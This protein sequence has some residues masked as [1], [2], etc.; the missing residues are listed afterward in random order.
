MDPRSPQDETTATPGASEQAAKPLLQACPEQ[1]AIAIVGMSGRYPGADSL[2][3]YWRNLVDGRD[4][5]GEIPAT[6]WDVDAYFDPAIPSPGKAYSKWLGSLEDIE[7][8]DPLFFNIAP[9]EAQRMDP[10]Q[11]LFLEEG[12]RAFEDAGLAPQELSESRC[13]VYLGIS[14]S[15]Y[16]TL[17]QQRL[18]LVDMIGSSPAIAA[19][20]IAYFLNLKG[21]AI[22]VDTACSS[23]LVAMHL[24]CQA[25]RNG[26][27]DLALAGGVAL[28]L[29]PEL[30]VC[31]CAAGV[32]SPRGK[33]RTL[34]NQADG[35]VPGEGVGA[36]V[37][38]RLADA[39][40]DGDLIHGLIIGSGINQDGRSNGL[41]APN[42]D[43]QAALLREVYQRHGIDPASIGYVEMHGTG[44]KLGDPI[45]LNALST[46]FREGTREPGFCGL[47]SVKS[48]IGHTSAAAG[49]AGVHKVLLQMRHRQLVPTLNYSSPNEHFDLKLEQS[50]FFVC[51]SAQPWAPTS[52][53]PLRAAVSSFGISGTNA[54]LVLEEYRR[55]QA[56]RSRVELD[57]QHPLLIVLSA[58]RPAQLKSYAAR[59]KGFL[60]N[61]TDV[62]WPALAHT[63]QV[64]RAPLEQ[65]LAFVATAPG[66]VIAT[67]AAFIEGQPLERVVVGDVR[68]SL[69]R[70][71]NFDPAK[72]LTGADGLALLE[73][74]REWVEGTQI[75][76]RSLYPEQPGGRIALP[77]YPFA[78]ERYW[79]EQPPDERDEPGPLPS[80]LQSPLQPLFQYSGSQAGEQRFSTTLTGDEFFLRDHQVAGQ[81]LV[82]AAMQLE[83]ARAAMAQAH[84]LPA[85][86]PVLLEEITWLRPLALRSPL[87]VH[88]GLREQGEG[89]VAYRIFSAG[90]D[91]PLVYSQG[92]ARLDS[93]AKQPRVDLQ[94]L[95]AGC[96]R[97]LDGATCYGR[98]ARLGLDYGP[99]FQVLQ[100]LELGD[101]LVLARLRGASTAPGVGLPAP[102]IDG[103]LQASLGLTA[104]DAL[105][106][107]FALQRLEQWQALPPEVWAILRPATNDRGK[108]R[109]IDI[110]LTD[111]EGRVMVRLNGFSS[112]APADKSPLAA[113]GT[114]PLQE[115]SL[116]PAWEPILEQPD[117]TLSDSRPVGRV[118]EICDEVEQR[119]LT[120]GGQG[121]WQ[122]WLQQQ[123]PF[124]HLV[125]HVPP[126]QPW[127]AKAA[128]LLIKALLELGH[129]G[130]PLGLCVV[131]RQALGVGPQ[132]L[133]DPFQAS[134]HGLIGSLAKEYPNWR[135][136]LVDLAP[137]D[138]IPWP[139][140]LGRT[141]GVAG[142]TLA[143]RQGRGY[144]QRLLA[145][146]LT[147]PAQPAFRQAGVYV[148]LGGAGGIGVAF[149][150]YLIRQ[151][152]AQV[153]WLGRRSEDQAI[154]DQCARLAALGPA[155]L[156][157]QADGRDRAALEAALGEIRGRYGAVHGVVHAALV[158]A[159]RSLAQMDEQTFEA[160]LAAKQE[161]ALNLDATFG[162]EPLDLMLYFSSLQSFARAA[163]QGNYAAGCCFVDEFARS[164]QR[165]YPVKLVHWGYW[166]GVG[167]VASPDYR[168]RMTQAGIGSIEPPQA[169]AWLENW[170]AG[171]L[172]RLGFAK[173]DLARVAPAWGI[174]S[175][176]VAELMPAVPAVSL[177]LTPVL[178]PPVA[179][180][181]AWQVLEQRLK[182][183]L[184]SLL[185]EH[186]WL[187]TEQG[188]AP[189]YQRWRAAALRLAG[190]S[191]AD[192]GWDQQWSQWQAYCEQVLAGAEPRGLETQ[193]RLLDQMLRALPTILRG[194]REA[195]QVLFPEGRLDG[196][197]AL[198]RD[199]PVADHFNAVLGE[200]L[201]AYVEQRLRLEPQA[202]LRILEVGA[203]TGGTSAGL[204]AR[205]A[206]YAGQIDEYAYTDVSPAF[207]EHAQQHYAPQAGY[208]RTGLLDIERDPSSQGFQAGGY[209][210]VVAANVL[211]ATRD[212]TRT[213]GQVKSLLKGNGLLLLNEATQAHL[214]GHL[215]FGLLPGW[216]L[217]EDPELRIP[218]T[219]MLTPASWRWVLQTQGFHGVDIPCGTTQAL[220]QEIILAISDGVVRH[221]V[222]PIEPLFAAPAGPTTEAQGAQSPVAPSG[223]DAQELATQVEAAITQMISDYLKI[224]REEL[225]R[226]TPFG[227]FG[228][229]SI[230]STAFTRLLNERY[231]LD[232]APSEFFETP[233]IAALAS[234]LAQEYRAE[235]QLFFTPAQAPRTSEASAPQAAVPRVAVAQGSRGEP[236]PTRAGAEPIAVI[237]MS[238]RFPEAE[239]IDALWRN[240]EAGRDCIGELP[241]GRFGAGPEPALRH[242]GVLEDLDGFDP[243]FF[244]ISRREAQGM[245]P[246]HRLLMMQVYKVIEDAGY[247][248]QS[249]SGS[250]TALLVGTC[251]T[252]YAQ[253]LAQSGEAVTAALAVGT[254]GSMGPNRMS[255]WLN[256]HGPSEPIE[257]ACSSSLVAVHRAVTL[258]RTGQCDQAVVGG[259]NT[260]LSA[261]AHES[262]MHAGVLSGDGRCRAFSAR[263]GGYVRGEGVAMLMLKP[264]SAAERDGDQIHGL[265]LGSAQNHGGQA[266]SLTAPN[267]QAQAK[268]IETALRE[269]GVDVS[270]IGYIEA[271]GTGTELGDPIEIKG[272]KQAFRTL[273][274][275]DALAE[276]SVGLGTI[277]SNIGHLEL[278][279]GVAGLV[280]VLLQMRHGCLVQ[281][282]HSQPLNPQIE[283]A[284]SP[285]YVV[286]AKRPWPALADGR[287]NVLP[288]RAGVSSFGFGGVN[289]HVVL[290]EYRPQSLPAQPA[291]AKPVLV[292][293]S[294]R[295][296]TGLKAR[297][298]QLLAFLEHREAD[299][300]SLAYTL[301]VGREAMKVR[302]ACVV[303]STDGLRGRLRAYLGGEGGQGEI[304][305]GD[306]KRDPGMQMIF[307][308]DEDLQETASRLIA[309][310]KL[311]R[312]AQWWVL[313]LEI[314]WTRLYGQQRP[315]RISLPT[316]PFALERCWVQA[317]AKPRA[318]QPH[319]EPAPIASLPGKPR[320]LR[321]RATEERA[322]LRA[323]ASQGGASSGH[324]TVQV[325]AAHALT[326]APRSISD[327][328]TVADLHQQNAGLDELERTLKE[329]LA[330]A[331]RIDVNEI[332][333]D[334]M[335]SEHG[336]D[337]II[338][339]EWIRELNRLYSISIN[340]S[341]VYEFPTIREMAKLVQ[342]ARERP[343]AV[344]LNTA[345]DE[346]DSG[347]SLGTTQ[348]ER[349]VTIAIQSQPQ[350][351]APAS[352]SL[353]TQVDQGALEQELTT[354][355]AQSLR[356]DSQE[357]DPE[358]MLAEHGLDSIIAVEWIREI[359]QR[360]SISINTSQVYEHPTIRQL[361]ALV[362]QLRGTESPVIPGT[363][364]PVASAPQRA[365]TPSQ[366]SLDPAPVSAAM[367]SPAGHQLESPSRVLANQLRLDTLIGSDILRAAAKLA[368]PTDLPPSQVLLTGASGFAGRFLALDLAQGLAPR[369]GTLYCL[370]RATSDAAARQRLLESL[371]ASTELQQRLVALERSGRL[372]VLAGDLTK[373]RLGLAQ[374][375][376]DMLVH[377]VEAI[378]HNGALVNH[379]L[380]Y[381]QLHG[382]NVH[383]TA[384]VIRLALSGK[385]KAINFISSI[386]VGSAVHRN[387]PIHESEKALDLYDHCLG[388]G[389]YA[390]GYAAS[391]WAG[392]VLLQEAW[393]KWAIPVKVFRCGMLLP[394]STQPGFVNFADIF[395]R[396][397]VSLV[398]TA[399]APPSFHLDSSRSMT[400]IFRGLPV[401]A[402]ARSIA[403][404]SLGVEAGYS[405]YHVQSNAPDAPSLDVLVDWVR[406]L[407]Y[408]L[409]KL[410][411]SEAWSQ[412]FVA[413]LQA[414][415]ARPRSYSL[416]SSIYQ[417]DELQE[418][419]N[420][421][422]FD[423]HRFAERTRSLI[424]GP[425]AQ[426]WLAPIDRKFISGYLK[427]LANA[428]LI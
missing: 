372:V 11:R 336:L 58:K 6:R 271:H 391:K 150:E 72:A 221:A 270:S 90:Q 277:K 404:I 92:R 276:R 25:L 370:V 291:Q 364:Q 109:G 299:L 99:S 293:L 306:I 326:Q 204:L 5:V 351:A 233:T 407:G 288:R 357:I 176:E 354:S 76:W 111:S 148:I 77:T 155:P 350:V 61:T 31:M 135:L 161:T 143:Y 35:F 164:A 420:Q 48:N 71:G 310:G 296:A 229:D 199:H 230:A 223:L 368:Q 315:R 268:V 244:N 384:E 169:M 385:K 55:P 50:P 89:T 127:A 305:H 356:I 408:P 59:L 402:A 165:P 220:S 123:E 375:T 172:E 183:L 180:A 307:Q 131:T 234:Y 317:S 217:A 133:G 195:T 397:L 246:Q 250:N 209:D 328:D 129:G 311:G 339:V 398:Q 327:I 149:S 323:V 238:G 26:E 390:A 414:L 201:Q 225:D 412:E 3:A 10:Q 121:A 101:D 68:K 360:Y 312:L 222:T 321:L 112:R 36:L 392:E 355:L 170:L 130:R 424:D 283:L 110:D 144:R 344:A 73:L 139:A 389:R 166:G 396:F 157:L 278:A 189:R 83:W 145:C 374:P 162:N 154:A 272:L 353:R 108:Q 23:S 403:Q 227:E 8:F 240:L 258:L 96:G 426:D 228:F 65:R 388:A 28:Y 168:A 301:Q 208:L 313:G 302:L 363:P 115:L 422:E 42:Q 64:G 371:A 290:E 138:P 361:A 158:L 160:A 254:A 106:L 125:W 100:G 416:Y 243:A 174:A 236:G 120:A 78:R 205:L 329:T 49:V 242:A 320:G 325:A 53:A 103:A 282:L 203:G 285:F 255:Y 421:P 86:H 188:L 394:H 22:P 177:P 44:T 116:M 4:C 214:F 247:S 249:L 193:V 263:A 136:D 47:G 16:G 52:G 237:G 381:N 141:P 218:G 399:I 152:Q 156:Y 373:P 190:H 410:G 308:A 393:E 95:R 349:A 137:Q 206:P 19:A 332:D 2:E 79:I 347:Q 275:K 287:G 9:T 75:D 253:L 259:V 216:W 122:S 289:A 212:I 191:E 134:V 226:N 322:E 319:R 387:E 231:G 167:V 118:V 346:Q 84:G 411:S 215:T 30:Y 67:L 70:T 219:P 260:L 184:Y 239:D 256:W 21:P 57:E 280:K 74:G 274:G 38:K 12:Y 88:V 241:L 82:P 269:A 40:R 63:L 56:S 342:Q 33:C 29:M 194:E 383:G 337:S 257:T 251:A 119:Q 126:G 314:D 343:R 117:N 300:Q 405:I 200:R 248:V 297:V 262:F 114:D 213:L 34:D 379:M 210:V 367:A 335:L 132:E 60:E 153:V 294:A 91:E 54:H 124:E 151:Y 187:A 401:D 182:P 318:S 362:G 196:V 93:S 198:Y 15:E 46:V 279:A 380:A 104:S 395:S 14:G 107:P 140:L 352:A 365:T 39:E 330:A 224:A 159:D 13:G 171:P 105:A 1:A 146:Q 51:T 252:G 17:V 415:D 211:H 418:V 98:F 37:L 69:A 192:T 80:A 417:L 425:V 185:Q 173:L 400:P 359:N 235:L 377:K 202:R 333:P 273:A 295:D 20:R 413:R 284:G 369:A 264:L 41:T 102:L 427:E 245:D 232:M 261:E 27:V 7:C 62:D 94:Q 419:L 87:Q 265:I 113:K 331:L 386:A 81:P 406:E 178:A 147:T 24:A 207:L 128:F 334:E 366:P 175:D 428:G 286:D 186:G 341:Q 303:D 32:L 304:F 382:T 316:Y 18:G 338:A 345:A 181:S 409:E 298:E 324:S 85:E 348:M 309:Q 266:N 97:Q 197:E 423:S 376:W 45:E 163:G 292:L 378:V 281:S 340:T 358:E 179:A 267:P 43:S 142:E 66:Q